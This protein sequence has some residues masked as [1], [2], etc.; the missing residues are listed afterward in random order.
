MITVYLQPDETIPEALFRVLGI[1]PSEKTVLP[2]G[3]GFIGDDIR[4]TRITP[5]LFENHDLPT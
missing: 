4:F 2:P 1:A 5:P 3:I